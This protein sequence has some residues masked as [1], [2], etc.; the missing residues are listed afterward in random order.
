MFIRRVTRSFFWLIAILVLFFVYSS[1]SSVLIARPV[2]SP[3][4]SDKSVSV[5]ADLATD[6]FRARLATYFPKNAWETKD[7][8]IL[9]NEQTALVFQKYE[10]KANGEITIKPCTV[11]MSNPNQADE[12]PIIMQ[13]PQGAVMRFDK[14]IDLKTATVGKPV[15][16]RL[17]GRVKIFSQGEGKHRLYLETSNIQ[18][19]RERLLT[20]NQ[21]KFEYEGSRGSGKVLIIR[22][23]KTS[24]KSKSKSGLAALESI[25]LVKLNE[26]YLDPSASSILDGEKKERNEDP[27]KNVPVVVNSDGPFKIDFLTEKLSF[28]K[29][30]VLRRLN[31][32]GKEDRLTCDNLDLFFKYDEKAA[33]RNQEEFQLDRV[34]AHGKPVVLKAPSKSAFFVGA[35]LEYDFLHERFR[36][37]SN[38]RVTPNDRASIRFE[39]EGRSHRIVAKDIIYTPG[40]EGK[41]GRLHAKGPGEFSSSSDKEDAPI[42]VSWNDRLVLKPAG[43]YI[44]K[45]DVTR[46]VVAKIGTNGTLRGQVVHVWLEDAPARAGARGDNQGELVRPKRFVAQGDVSFTSPKL[47][48]SCRELTADIA[49]DFTVIQGARR[50][51]D[52]TRAN[53]RPARFHGQQVSRAGRSSMPAFERFPKESRDRQFFSSDERQ[54]NDRYVKPNSESRLPVSVEGRSIALHLTMNGHEDAHVDQVDVIGDAKLIQPAEDGMSGQETSITADEFRVRQPTENDALVEAH[55]RPTVVSFDGV[56]VTAQ[57]L[58]LDQAANKLWVDCPGEAEFQL[59]QDIEGNPIDE[60]QQVVLNW[61]DRM[62]FDGTNI[63]VLGNVRVESPDFQASA[64]SMRAVLNQHI[65]FQKPERK[66]SKKVELASFDAV[67]TVQVA[68]RT[69][70]E[71][72]RLDSTNFFYGPNFHLNHQTGDARIN[73]AGRIISVRRG[74]FQMNSALGRRNEPKQEK[75]S[76]LSYLQV[77]FTRSANGN[78]NQKQMEFAD[79]VQT[80]Y[81]PINQWNERISIESTLGEDDIVLNSERMVIAQLPAPTGGKPVIDLRAV[82]SVV[83]KGNAF[84]AT[85]DQVT[86][87]QAKDLLILKGGPYSDATIKSESEGSKHFSDTSGREIRFGVKRKEVQ[88]ND[89][90]VLNF[91]TFAK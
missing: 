44:Q 88:F 77:D 24:F 63:N 53:I 37:M 45:L 47:T 12:P 18:I 19:D 35:R 81:G 8:T 15:S 67:G 58:R 76:E 49:H 85:G 33:D 57:T 36:A 61:S 64:D 54:T 38:D 75:E 84:S 59:E 10:P 39:K 74:S 52:S 17:I 34:V 20:P 83:V 56:K 5:S 21:V 69:W 7:V 14:P 46:N 31:P 32:D 4:E 27:E 91:R 16:G 40:Q 71:F 43:S 51:G 29:N 41:L 42:H 55:G 9:R 50:N 73:G 6:P 48:A 60:P 25:E 72:G 26:L 86:F 80:I 62:N 68:Y 1:V 70:G 23:A 13:A 89:V 28:E 87:D 11:V 30:V 79:Q 90:R 22:L 2:A 65:R 66:R 82:G 3:S 78:V